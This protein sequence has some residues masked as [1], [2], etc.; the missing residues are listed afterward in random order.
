MTNDSLKQTIKRKLDF[1]HVH[2]PVRQRQYR[3]SETDS[4]YLMD[5]DS[6]NNKNLERISD[7]CEARLRDV[8]ERKL[9]EGSS[10]L[11]K[12]GSIRYSRPLTPESAIISTVDFPEVCNES[13]F[14]DHTRKLFSTE[15]ASSVLDSTD[16]EIL[17]KIENHSR[18]Y[19][20]VPVLYHKIEKQILN[21]KDYENIDID[22]LKVTRSTQTED[23]NKTYSLTSIETQTCPMTTQ[24]KNLRSERLP[25]SSLQKTV[26]N[27]RN[28]NFV[29]ENIQ[30]VKHK[31]NKFSS[32]RNATKKSET[33]STVKAGKSMR[34]HR[35]NLK[36]RSLQFSTD[37]EYDEYSTGSATNF[38]IIDHAASLK[39]TCDDQLECIIKMGDTL[40]QMR[41]DVDEIVQLQG[42]IDSARQTH[43]EMAALRTVEDYRRMNGNVSSSVTN[44]DD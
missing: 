4:L 16:I 19:G 23:A 25:C 27:C 22:S 14:L 35:K 5:I 24:P 32:N 11:E 28:R 1:E 29:L 15:D 17:Q 26:K 40:D 37:E 2:C 10:F 8:H 30:N 9:R 18:S 6:N 43:S 39:R 44:E 7:V 31:C 38:Q 41:S 20:T 36:R 33:P 13:S 34:K 3:D 12:L 21:R 42:E